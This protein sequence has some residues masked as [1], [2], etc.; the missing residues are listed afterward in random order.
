[1]AILKVW[2]IEVGAFLK[3]YYPELEFTRR[4]L[5]RQIDKPNRPG[6]FQI[7]NLQF[8]FRLDQITQ[9]GDVDTLIGGARH[10][11]K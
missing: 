6:K 4:E 8:L 1:M 9:N 3:G 5:A 11:M 10:K 2:L 7:Y